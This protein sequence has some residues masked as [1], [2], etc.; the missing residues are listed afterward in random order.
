MSKDSKKTPKIGDKVKVSAKGTVLGIRYARKNNEDKEAT[1]LIEV[2]LE[3]GR[4]INFWPD[5]IKKKK[6]E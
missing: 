3:S 6:Q 2:Q 4:V 1:P 5:E